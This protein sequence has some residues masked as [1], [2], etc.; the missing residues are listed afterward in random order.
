MMR[1]AAV[2]LAF[3]LVC[4]A[5]FAGDFMSKVTDHYAD[6]N[7]VKI[8]YVKAGQGPLVVFIHGFPDFWY[9]WHKQMEGLMDEYT[10]VAMDT[11]GYNLSDK[12]EGVENYDMSLL[13]GD[14][15]AVIKAAG[16]DKAVIVGHDW[17]GAIAWSFAAMVPQMT[18]KL[19]IVN[20]P[21]LECMARELANNPAQQ[22]NSQYARNFQQPDSHTRLN[23]T[24]L[25]T[26]VS[27]G[28]P[29]DKAIY[30]K[31]FE[32]SSFDSMMNYY[33]RN[34]PSGANEA[35]ERPSLPKITMPV[36]QFHG[37]T[38]TALMP[39]GLNNTWEYLEKDWT[40]VTFPGVGHWSH[41]EKADE[42]T[43]M[44]RAWLALHQ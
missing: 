15:A 23:A 5:A 36:L 28:N 6:S 40:L 37:L 1:Q 41:H 2:S 43:N 9:S 19:I 21:H 35:A 20:L 31:A 33:R 11:R 18:D 7:G 4:S 25:A 34:Y 27:R 29:E 26:M 3:A 12:P 38:D 42:V 39:G 14:V 17:G 24:M 32:N 30:Q 10:V 13:V 16:A 44:M 8:H 22:A